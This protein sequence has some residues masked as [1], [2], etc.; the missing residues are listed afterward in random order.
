MLFS[1]S[2]NQLPYRTGNTS[3][4]ARINIEQT[5]IEQSLVQISRYRFSLVISGLTKMLQRANEA[6]SCNSTYRT[7]PFSN[8]NF[9]QY[10]STQGARGHDAERLGYDS[11]II[12]LQTLE[13]CLSGQSKDTQRFEEALNV[14][15]L[16]REICQ[17][18]G[19]F[20]IEKLLAVNE[21]LY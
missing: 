8:D 7:K 17:F 20:I 12:I 2:H 16:L 4:Q 10:Q 5:L 6:V 14:K 21:N 19:N 3:T 15:L 13:R 1:F 9:F 11:L 18:I